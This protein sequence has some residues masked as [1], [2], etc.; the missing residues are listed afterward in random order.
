M[1]THSLLSMLRVWSNWNNKLINGC[2]VG[3]VI[4]YNVGYDLF[5]INHKPPWDISRPTIKT[6]GSLRVKGTS[7]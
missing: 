7:S 5:K 3:G 1:Y 2:L 4:F 6:P